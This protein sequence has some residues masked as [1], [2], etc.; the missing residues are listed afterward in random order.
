MRTQIGESQGW[1]Q[2]NEKL[3]DGGGQGWSQSD[4]ML[5]DRLKK[6]WRRDGEG[7]KL[8]AEV[9]RKRLEEAGKEEA[10]EFRLRRVGSCG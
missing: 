8:I 5:D 9:K 4:K 7:Y 2:S 6:G 10:Q 1:R 3:A